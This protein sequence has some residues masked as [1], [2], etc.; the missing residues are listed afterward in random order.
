MSLLIV[1]DTLLKL[2]E[3][4]NHLQNEVLPNLRTR[5]IMAD[6]DNFKQEEDGLYFG[7]FVCLT[8]TS[9]FYGTAIAV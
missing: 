6:E 1:D 3:M 9:T 5:C 8:A 2:Q 4:L 7:A